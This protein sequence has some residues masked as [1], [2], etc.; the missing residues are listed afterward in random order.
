MDVHK[1]WEYKEYFCI[2]GVMLTTELVYELENSL[3]LLQV[4]NHFKT[5]QY[6]GKI[7]ATE[8][9][10]H[11][12]VGFGKDAL[13]DKKYFYT[14]DFKLWSLLPKPKKKYKY[15]S[16]MIPLPF[17]GDPSRKMQILDESLEESDPE[18]YQ[19]MKEENRL[20]ATISNICDEAEICARGQI[21]KHPDLSVIINP[22][23]YGLELAEAKRLKSYM[24]IR[25]A[26]HRWNTNLLTRPD[27]NYS[28]DFLDSIDMDIPKGCWNVSLE[29]SGNV[30]YLKNLYWPGVIFFHKIGTPDA[31]FLYAGNGYKNFDM[32][33]L[34]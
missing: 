33:F 26:Q 9:D 17:C 24:H 23:F 25:P 30:V 32:P 19:S 4:E 22:H 11:I 20:A 1:L 18:R 16:L 21:I 6:W 7:Y 28:M 15:L 27:Y 10:Y 3:T 5:I 8:N 2:N 34:I 29:H 14:T 31:G 13:N 12:A